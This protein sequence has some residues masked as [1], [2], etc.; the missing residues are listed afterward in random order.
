MF[1]RTVTGPDGRRWKLGR[2]W[3]PRFRRIKKAD[4]TDFGPDLPGFDG[5]DDLGIVGAIFAAILAVIVAVF[6]ALL[7]FNVIALAIELAIFLV[8]LIAGVIA[9]V[10]F[11][12]PWRVFAATQGAYAYGEV[13][14]WRASREWLRDAETRIASGLNPA[15]G[16]GRGLDD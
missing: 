5:L 10:L 12:K 16:D 3:F 13:T 7:L 6:L 4:V 14:G 1:R 15:P 8:L 9:R 11:R 2:T